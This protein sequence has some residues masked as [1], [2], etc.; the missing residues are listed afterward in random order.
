MLLFAGE[1]GRGRVLR[2]LDAI[3]RSRDI[4]LSD[5]DGLRVSLKAPQVGNDAVRQALVDELELNPAD[6]IIGEPFYLMGRG[7]GRGQLNEIGAVLGQC[8]EVAQDAAA[9]LLLG[10]H[11]N[12]GGTGIGATASR[13]RGCTNG[14]CVVVNGMLEDK[15]S[16]IA[17]RETVADVRWDVSGEMADVGFKLRRLVRPEDPDNPESRLV[18]RCTFLGDTTRPPRRCCPKSP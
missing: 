16:D 2:R 10:D 6:L 14:P 8:Q 7:V 17:T 9:A 12:K 1:G 4:D 13:A 5:I 11:W 3:A 18:Y 15:R